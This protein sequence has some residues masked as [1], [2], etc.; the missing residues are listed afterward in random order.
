VT[1]TV[2][3]AATTALLDLEGAAQQECAKQTSTCLTIYTTQD[4]TNWEK[5]YGPLFYQLYP[6]AQGKVS[7][8]SLAAATETARLT[9][10]Y[11][12]KNVQCDLATGTLAGLIPVYKIGAFLNYTS[13]IA[14][15]MNY[16]A[17]GLGPA[18]VVTNNAVVHMIYNP[19]LLTPSQVPKN[20]SAL[21]NP[22]YKGKL[23][24]QSAT[25]LSIT[26]AEFYYLYTVMGNSSGQWTNLMKG[27]AAN[28][29]MITATAGA[30]ETAV[31]NGQAAIGID[32]F[33]GYV[34]TL[35]ANPAAPLKLVDIEPLVYTPGV[36]A[37]TT[38]APHPAMAKLV[39]A[40]FISISGQSGIYHANRLPYTALIGSAYTAYLPPN[41]VLANAYANTALFQNTGAWSDTF[42]AIFGA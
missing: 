3:A 8:N 14:K 30:A 11:Q 29:P 4:Q 17:D 38:G 36:V 27:I 1:S 31:L 6:W 35:K 15:F 2:T 21:A 23:A 26:T 7:Y 40:W 37:I 34:T 9:S 19:T 5:Y 28:Q 25:S 24:F 10:E 42:K 13:P 16:S 32:T 41:Y 22:I 12:A 39:E 33:D 18:W 20:W